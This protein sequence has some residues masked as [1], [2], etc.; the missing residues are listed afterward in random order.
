MLAAA[1][2]PWMSRWPALPRSTRRARQFLQFGECLG[3]SRLA[4]ANRSAAR[5]GAPERPRRGIANA[6]TGRRGRGFGLAAIELPLVMKIGNR[7]FTSA[8]HE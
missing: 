6:A 1:V 5:L 3:H 8:L 2:K 7:Q 4:R